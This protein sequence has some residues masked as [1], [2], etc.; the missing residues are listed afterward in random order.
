[1]MT[2][3][4]NSPDPVALALPT[5]AITLLGCPARAMLLAIMATIVCAR[6][7]PRAVCLDN[8]HRGG[9]SS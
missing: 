5:L 6:P 7:V 2:E 8:Q 3:S 1:M 9:S 4:V